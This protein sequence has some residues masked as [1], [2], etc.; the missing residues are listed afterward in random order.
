MPSDTIRDQVSNV[1]TD[2]RNKNL[3]TIFVLLTFRGYRAAVTSLVFD[4]F[5]ESVTFTHFYKLHLHTKVKL[6]YVPK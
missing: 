6:K 5:T 4:Y 1:G 3:F 2:K